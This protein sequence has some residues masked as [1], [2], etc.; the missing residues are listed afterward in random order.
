MSSFSET[1]EKCGAVMAVKHGRYGQFLACT[2]YPECQ[3]TRQLHP[4]DQPKNQIEIQPQDKK[5]EKCG[6]VMA[7]KHGRYGPFLACTGFPKCKNIKKVQQKTG[8]RCPLCDTGE[9]IEKR[10]R[11]GKTF[12][13]CNRY[14]DCAFALWARPTGE[15]CPDCGSLLVFSTGKT[16]SCSGKGCTYKKTA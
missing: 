11:A 14:P 4:L 10:S 5:C 13:S 9:I 1:C 12:Y 8:T 16:V 6:S 2:G 15:R 7:L 3:N